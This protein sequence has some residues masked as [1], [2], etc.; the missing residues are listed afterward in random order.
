M[1]AAGL[2]T[3]FGL[4]IKHEDLGTEGASEAAPVAVV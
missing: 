1:V 4:S 2:I 3:L